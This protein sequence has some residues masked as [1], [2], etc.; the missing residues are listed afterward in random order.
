ML[1]LLGMLI[2]LTLN[3]NQEIYNNKSII[4]YYFVVPPDTCI[5]FQNIFKVYYK[6]VI[7]IHSNDLF[8]NYH[9]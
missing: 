1:L 5:F 6:D 9:L 7:S 2:L 3:L 4:I 8:H